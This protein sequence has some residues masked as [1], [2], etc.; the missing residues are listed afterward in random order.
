MRSGKVSTP[1]RSESGALRA[2]MQK[3]PHVRAHHHIE[4][5]RYLLGVP[6]CSPG[7]KVRAQLVAGICFHNR[8]LNAQGSF[9]AR[10]HAEFPD[11]SDGDMPMSVP[12]AAIALFVS[13][14]VGAY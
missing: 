5:R 1:R 3:W 12:M 14:R 8:E 9:A 11:H 7:G 2:A 6:L 4:T 13:L 10:C